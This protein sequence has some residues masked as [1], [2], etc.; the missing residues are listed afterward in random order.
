MSV[1]TSLTLV[2]CAYLAAGCP[3][4]RPYDDG[5]AGDSSL[6]DLAGDSSPADLAGDQGD[7][8]TWA[9]AFFSTGAVSTSDVV[10]D[11]ADNLTVAGTFYKY[12]TFGPT[13]LTP[14]D[15]NDLFL[16]RVSSQG[17]VLW[18]RR[19]GGSGSDLTARL[20]RDKAGNLYLTGRFTKQLTFGSTTLTSQGSY[21][22]FL[23]KLDSAGKG[24]WARS[25]GGKGEDRGQGITAD[26]T[27]NVYVVGDYSA[28]A[29]FGSTSLTAK[30]SYDLF[31]AK[32]GASGNYLWVKSAGGAKVDRALAAAVAPDQGLLVTGSFNGEATFG[33]TK[34]TPG[35]TNPDIFVA[36]YEPSGAVSWAAVAGGLGTDSGNNIVVDGSNNCY[37]TGPFEKVATFGKAEVSSRGS[38]DVFVTKLNPAGTFVWAAAGGGTSI[39]EG[40]GITLDPAGKT[41]VTGTF[42]SKEATFGPAKLTR[43]GN[44]D[45][46]VARVSKA[47]TFDW[48]VSAGGDYIDGGSGLTVGSDGYLVATGFFRSQKASFGGHTLIL[49]DKIHGAYVW[50]LATQ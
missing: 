34:L 28:G 30:G 25:A 7:P 43:S 36:R 49:G 6:A 16:A 9:L 38:R 15:G 35:N 10:R 31:V 48:A 21:D 50:K 40:F 39:D 17:K 19:H 1:K 3:A 44:E 20:A 41:Y 8:N 4:P 32:L 37:V 46:F 24:L 14:A 5:A 23:A 29:L 42:L 22:V 12:S 13:P 2:L 26:A 18:A 27:G 33:S 11:S 47:G 45:A